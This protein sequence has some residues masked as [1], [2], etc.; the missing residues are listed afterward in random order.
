MRKAVRVQPPFRIEL[1][2]VGTPQSFVPVNKEGKIYD[3]GAAR[4]VELAVVVFR[5][6]RIGRWKNT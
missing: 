4:H 5:V 3:S 1:V 2:G 6:C